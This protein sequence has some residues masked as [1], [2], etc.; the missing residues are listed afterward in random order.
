M[1]QSIESI[2]SRCTKSPDAG[3]LWIVCGMWAIT[4]GPSIPE[5]NAGSRGLPVV[6]GE[7]PL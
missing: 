1:W 5:H 4:V 7:D 6:A 3:G 2:A